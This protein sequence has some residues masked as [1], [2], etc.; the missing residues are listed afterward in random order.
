MKR[1]EEGENRLS[2]HEKVDLT[3]EEDVSD[4]FEKVAVNY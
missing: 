2:W 1:S 4:F 3:A